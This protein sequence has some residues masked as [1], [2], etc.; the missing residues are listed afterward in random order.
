MTTEPT[1]RSSEA[2]QRSIITTLKQLTA[3]NFGEVL[4]D[5]SLL[6]TGLPGESLMSVGAL[7]G[8][9]VWN[10]FAHRPD[11]DTAD[12]EALIIA[13]STTNTPELLTTAETFDIAYNSTTDGAGGGATGAT[14]LTI[15]YLDASGSLAIAQ[16]TLGS[17]GN[18][19]TAFSGLGINRVVCSATGTN[20]VNVNDITITS[21]TSGGVQSFIPA[22][23]GTTQQAIFFCPSSGSRAV[24]KD[25][26]LNCTTF[27]GGG[28]PRV[29][30]KGKVWNRNIDSVFEVFRTII[31]TSS[32]NSIHI[33]N[34][35]FPLSLG[36]VLYWTAETD[37][38]N[39]VIGG[40][41][42]RLDV[43]PV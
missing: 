7:S 33:S 18:D 13:D 35:E 21:T 28:S 6:T 10:K 9:S 27:S 26:Y 1:K 31:D 25:V 29:T 42:F 19:T 2:V 5:G 20:Q 12:G 16:H 4:S 39:T 23:E 34:Q 24:G 22:G 30:F 11:L 3:A 43:I 14:E 37:T 36:D 8:Y 17:D 41:R 40:I 38:N 32:E 15:Y